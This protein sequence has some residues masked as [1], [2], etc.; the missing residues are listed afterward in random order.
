MADIQR[1]LQCTIIQNYLP[2]AHLVHYGSYTAAIMISNHIRN[3]GSCRPTQH[4]KTPLAPYNR[5]AHFPAKAIFLDSTTCNATF[6][7][8]V[9]WLHLLQYITSLERA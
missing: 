5:L 1:S 7:G 4:T 9:P 3:A 6:L 8:T 2:I